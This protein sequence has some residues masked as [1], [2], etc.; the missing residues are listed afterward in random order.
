MHGF[1]VSKVSRIRIFANGEGAE[2]TELLAE[3]GAKQKGSVWF[4]GLK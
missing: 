3:S 4:K 1:L 2:G